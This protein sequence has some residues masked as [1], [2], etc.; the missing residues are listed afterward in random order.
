M[1]DRKLPARLRNSI[2]VLTAAG[3]PIAVFG[4]GADPAWLAG[5]GEEA[6]MIKLISDNLALRCLDS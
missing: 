1:I 6:V 5:D 4:V 3:K 2:P